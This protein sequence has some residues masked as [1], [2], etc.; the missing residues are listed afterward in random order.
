VLEEILANNQVRVL[1]LTFMQ[2][3]SDNSLCR[4]VMNANSMSDFNVLVASINIAQT[5]SILLRSCPLI[6][7]SRLS[8]AS[9][10]IKNSKGAI[11][12]SISYGDLLETYRAAHVR[13]TPPL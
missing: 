4:N 13:R 10:T 5:I 2:Q 7:P 12:P 6:V 3:E 9:V 1:K 11:V 8:N